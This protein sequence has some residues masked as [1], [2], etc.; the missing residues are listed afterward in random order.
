MRRLSD[1]CHGDVSPRTR[2]LLDALPHALDLKADVVQGDEVVHSRAAQPFG[3]EEDALAEEDANAF[4]L[5]PEAFTWRDRKAGADEIARVRRE[6][7]VS[8][9]S[10]SA[11]E[12]IDGLR[13]I[14]FLESLPPGSK[15]PLSG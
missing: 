14:W 5:T 6:L 1:L 11:Q 9:G 8:F 15:T 2:F 12:P 7:F 10:C 4:E 3:D 13:D